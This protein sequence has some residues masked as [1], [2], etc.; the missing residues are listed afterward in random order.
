MATALRVR[1]SIQDIQDDYAKGNKAPL[2]A[3]MRAWK[4]IKELAPDDHRSFFWLGGL[5]GEPFR[6]AGWGSSAYWGGYCN[7]GNILFPTW[8]RVYCLKLEEALRSIPGCADVTLPYWD[9]TSEDSVTKGIPWALTQKDFVLD[10]N[11]IA[12]PL[13]SFIFPK[14]IVDNISGDDPSY[15][16]PKKYETVRYPLSG[17]VGSD[18]HRAATEK[19]NAFYPNYDTNVE[20]LNNNIVNWLTSVIIINGQPRPTH[21]KK[22]YEDCLN[23]P[24]YT[25]F[26]NTTSAAQWAQD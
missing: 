14:E 5:H 20:L 23:A 9:E 6:G 10:G 26:S 16:K 22:E 13:R 4:G 19:H 7:H 15:T 11:P 12:N 17:L 18:A 25:V 2:E 3:L 21:V 24:N 8:H 1:R